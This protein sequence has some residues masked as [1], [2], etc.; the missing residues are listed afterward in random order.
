MHPNVLNDTCVG[1]AKLPSK[2]TSAASLA[3]NPVDVALCKKSQGRIMHDHSDEDLSSWLPAS[4]C[5]PWLPALTDLGSR[6]LLSTI[7]PPK[8]MEMEIG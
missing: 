1:Y 2:C 7:G 4:L 5:A 6:I 8:E 3:F